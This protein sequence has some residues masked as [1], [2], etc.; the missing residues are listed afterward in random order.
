[1]AS[2][3]NS[4]LLAMH[5][6][7]LSVVCWVSACSASRV[8]ATFL[9]EQATS[10]EQKP[11]LHKKS[12]AP[13]PVQGPA[14][15]LYNPEILA[16][17]SKVLGDVHLV[18]QQMVELGNSRS[19][20]YEEHER[21][22]QS[23]VSAALR[24]PSLHALA[25]LVFAFNPIATFDP[26]GI[27]NFNRALQRSAHHPFSKD[28]SSRLSSALRTPLLRLCGGGAGD[29][30][31]FQDENDRC[32]V[33]MPIGDDI[34]PRDID[35]SLARNVLTLGVKGMAPV[36]DAELLWGRVLPDDATWEIDEVNSQRCVVLEMV[37]REGGRWDHLLVSQAKPADTTVTVQTFMDVAVDGEPAG[38]I[39]FGLYGNQV[40]KTVENF[41]SLCTGEKGEGASGKAL[42]FAGSPFH[43]IIPGFMLQGGD[44]TTGDGRG[45]E[46]IYGEKFADEDFT[47]KHEKEGLLS[48]ANSGPDS[49]GSQFFIT[50]AETPW[51]DGKHVVFG[52]VQKGMDV[53]RAVEKLGSGDGTPSKQVTIAA[54]GM[55]P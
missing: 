1:M 45:G 9:Q 50:V 44:F 29:P 4:V 33:T 24:H 31:T 30:F 43:R 52:E 27:T 39:E 20:Y 21:F 25:R 46:S 22:V 3:E 34:R 11:M 53:V 37:K 55:L 10:D 5:P 47:V 36:I 26:S 42:S 41:R 28:S 2:E 12:V 18:P 19:R 15:W 51:L 32:V 38:R 23:R 6:V 8:R 54:C 40:P 7:A 14:Q 13:A 49:N 17:S 16:E 35:F 48:M